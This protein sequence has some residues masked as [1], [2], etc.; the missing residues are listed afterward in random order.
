M[1]GGS[2]DAEGLPRGYPFRPA[3]EVTA[4]DAKRMLDQRGDSILIIDVRTLP[5]WDHAHVAGSIHIPLDEIERR[6]DEIAPAPGQMVACLCHHG[7]R[8]LKASL[9]LRQLGC[10]QAMSIA[11]GIDAWSLAADPSVRRYDRAGGVITPL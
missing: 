6:A 2:V 4:R 7:V 3:Y 10:P 11:G 8:S 1:S 5:E 9:A